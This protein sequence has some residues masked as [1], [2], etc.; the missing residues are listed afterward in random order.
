MH[1]DNISARIIGDSINPHNRR[2][3][4][5]VCRYPRFIHAELMTHRAFSRNAASSRA[6]P[7][8][9]MI[10]N[11][12]HNPARFVYWGKNQSGMQANEQLEPDKIETCAAIIRDLRHATINAVWQLENAGLHKQNANRYLEPF[13]HIEVLITATDYENFFAQRVDKN[14]QPEFQELATKMARAWLNSTPDK[15]EWGDWHIPCFQGIDAFYDGPGVSSDLI[16]RATA[17]CA[18]L[19]YLTFDGDASA[20]K[21]LQLHTDLVKNGHWS[22]FEHCAQ[23]KESPQYPWSNFDAP[24]LD[25]VNGIP[26]IRGL[27]HWLQYRKTFPGERRKISREELRQRIENRPDWINL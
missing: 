9:K 17:R 27:S 22:P 25:Q 18:R 7:L 24:E 14:A 8:K 2:L 5:F 19:S 20:A 26:V 1:L 6:I 4:S 12:E 15:L 3:T 11:V 13:G 16:E 21:D 10:G 23:A